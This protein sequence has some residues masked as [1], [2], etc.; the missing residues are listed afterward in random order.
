[1]KEAIKKRKKR[2]HEGRITV[3]IGRK[4][5]SMSTLASAT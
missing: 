1:M 3:E 5:N 4:D 2:R